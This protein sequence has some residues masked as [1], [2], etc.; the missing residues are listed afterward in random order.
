MTKPAE[1]PNE[2]TPGTNQHG[3]G[4][5]AGRQ[6][7]GQENR[8]PGGDQAGHGGPRGGPPELQD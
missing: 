8:F 6:A 7:G 5:W 1:K 3:P 4:N 2:R